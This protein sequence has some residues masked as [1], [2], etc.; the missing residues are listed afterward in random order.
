M[1]LYGYERETTPNLEALADDAVVFDAFFNAG[2]GT[3]KSHAS[4]FTSL[5]PKVH[6]VTTRHR[7]DERHQTLSEVLRSNGYL[8]A[9]FV[10]AV[11]L[12]RKYGFAQG[13]DSFDQRGG[14]LVRILPEALRWLDD[15]ADEPFFLFLHT[16]DVHSAS[17]RLP[18]Q[19]PDGFNDAFTADYD[20][21]FSG[22][23]GE[24]CA[25]ALLGHANR[26]VDR[27]GASLL[28]IFLPEELEYITGLYDG[29]I[30][31]VDRELGKL[32]SALKNRRLYDDTLLIVLADHG[33]E[34]ADHGRMLHGNPYDEY[35]RIP[36]LIKFPHSRHAGQRIDSLSSMVDVVPTLLDELGFAPEADLQGHSLLPLIETG[37]AVREYVFSHEGAI[38]SQRWKLIA[39]RREL[40][41]LASDP[42]EQNN[43][44][45]LH[46]DA[47]AELLK[48]HAEF[49]RAN[50]EALRSKR[51]F[52]PQAAGLTPQEKVQLE[53][54]GY[55]P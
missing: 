53:T 25:S 17:T 47:V 38:R 39:S 48:R 41:D 42:K 8:T 18:Y 4:L 35:V 21:E 33:E 45:E 49:D 50:T 11:W 28:D 54:L 31:Y 24:L 44:F 34:L 20:G 30:S 10:D 3:L 1:S 6:R 15:H 37:E 9:A 13:F 51:A 26:R 7:L 2:G 16:F 52:T 36:L 5:Y 29:G 46:P 12:R 23:I 14:N 19:S 40:F 32:V 22:C 55:S 27:D 43:V